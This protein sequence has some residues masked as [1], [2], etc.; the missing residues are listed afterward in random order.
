[1]IAYVIIYGQGQSAVTAMTE[2]RR[3]PNADHVHM[4]HGTHLNLSLLCLA[5]QKTSLSRAKMPPR[6]SATP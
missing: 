5:N 6:F 3:L 1:M 2:C 4:S